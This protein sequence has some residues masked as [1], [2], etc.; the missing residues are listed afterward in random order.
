MNERTSMKALA[1]A[2]LETEAAGDTAPAGGT[3]GA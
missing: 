2:I 3:S 1:Q